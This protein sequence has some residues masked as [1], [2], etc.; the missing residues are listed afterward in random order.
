VRA[1]L[2]GACVSCF[3]TWVL[4]VMQPSVTLYNMTVPV[5]GEDAEQGEPSNAGGDAAAADAP[6]Q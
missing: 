5:G 2:G 1:K 6:A 3:Y 4:C